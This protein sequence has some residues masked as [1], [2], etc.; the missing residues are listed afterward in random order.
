MIVVR[1]FFFGHLYVT[2]G[3]EVPKYVRVDF[4]TKVT[5]TTNGTQES[6]KSEI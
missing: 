4:Q 2:R 3:K 1:K 5:A 6:S